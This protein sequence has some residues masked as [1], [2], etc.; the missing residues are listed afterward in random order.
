[1]KIT[2]DATDAMVRE[3]PFVRDGEVHV[4]LSAGEL[5]IRGT[6]EELV[7]IRS[8][9]GRPVDEV[10]K[11]STGD[12][13][14]DIRALDE[15]AVRIGPLTIGGRSS[16][17]LQIDVPRSTRIVARTAS[18][19]I[20]ADGL[21]ADSRW[22]AASGDLQITSQGGEIR[23]E[24]MSGDV[25]IESPGPLAVVGRTVSG[26]TRIRAP[27]LQRLDVGTTSGDIDVQGDLDAGP[28][29]F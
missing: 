29:A 14:V 23:F 11:V 26:G 21:A 22:A 7:R 13:A 28:H 1:M 9:D 15:P 27:R 17:E 8:T 4:M 2:V 16:A 24:S 3:L 5:R 25:T 18:S 20:F 19:D 10:V 6:D 12:A